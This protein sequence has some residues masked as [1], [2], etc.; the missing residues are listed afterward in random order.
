MK[1]SA[2]IQTCI[3]M[4][5][6]ISE[7]RVPMDSA[8]GDYMRTRR[9][10]GAKDRS[11]IAERVYRVMRA[12]ARLSWWIESLKLPPMPRYYVALEMMLIDGADLARVD[13]LF[14]GTQYAPEKLS[15]SERKVLV[16]VE[17]KELVHAAMPDTVRYECPPEHEESLRAYFGDAF[18]V[19]M[20]AMLKAATLDVRVNT[21]LIE[22]DKV[23]ASLLKDGI[24]TKATTLSPWG[25]AC[26]RKA[27]LSK[28]KAMNK[29]WIS[30]QD[31]GSQM[32]S[33]VC[34]AQA[35]M[36]VLDYCAGGGGKT[37]ALASA[38]GRKGRIVAM[39]LDAQRLERGKLRYK[40]AQV[41]DMIE[42][43]PLSE[44]RNRKWLRRQK[45][46]FDRVL[47]DV[48]CSGTGTWRRNPDMRW[49]H[50]GPELEE[51]RAT[52]AEILDKV[53]GCVKPGGKLIYATCSLLPEENEAQIE[54]FLARHEDFTV[55][56][57]D[58]RVRSDNSPYMRLTPHRHGTDGFFAA[59]M[60]RN[61]QTASE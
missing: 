24:E 42:V 22:R 54:A 21:F 53:A 45:G 44:E 3:E 60:I 31:E 9:F 7:A 35:G 48:P 50:L 13:S 16:K 5:E 33:Y 59:V 27:Y 18:A 29:G 1:P 36:Q 30:I 2:R 41:A 51:L 20:E 26:N 39:D 46:T 52:Q 23:Q 56:S 43:R 11:A 4:L 32:I 37:L 28:S 8:I 10:I 34:G 49:R 6:R 57:V 15:A 19:E 58:E 14:D 61:A 25:L 12:H 47:V 17:G 38:M 40:K 55:E